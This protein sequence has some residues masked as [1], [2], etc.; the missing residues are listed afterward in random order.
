MNADKQDYKRSGRLAIR[1]SGFGAGNLLFILAAIAVLSCVLMLEKYNALIIVGAL[2]L[3]YAAYSV[4]R[5]TSDRRDKIII[6]KKGITFFESH[7]ISLPWAEIRYAY[8]KETY[9]VSGKTARTVGHLIVETQ[10]GEYSVR[11]A[12][13]KYNASEIEDAVNYFSGRNIGHISVK[14]NRSVSGLLKDREKTEAAYA[15]FGKY[16]KRQ[17]NI[18][19]LWL[20]LIA[21][22]VYLQVVMDYPYVFAIGF[23]MSSIV[24]LGAGYWDERRIRRNSFLKETD[25]ETYKKIRAE[26]GKEYDMKYYKHEKL[27]VFIL[28]AIM[29]SAAFGVSYLFHI[30]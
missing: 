4:I 23:T 20:F 24:A 28:I 15:F 21:V 13:L 17:S 11:M 3:V 5:A 26:Y 1:N 6:D 8:V 25:D 18:V 30:G 19:Y 7:E 16:Y 27:L 12:R 14:L 9:E 2:I 10:S 29:V 22:S